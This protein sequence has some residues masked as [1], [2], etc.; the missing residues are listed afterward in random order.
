MSFNTKEFNITAASFFERYA[1]EREEL[2]KCL[3]SKINEDINL[4]CKDTKQKYLTGI[5]HTFC[6]IEYEDARRCQED[7][8]GSH[9]TNCFDRMVKFGQCTDMT[10]RKL[11][12]FGLEHHRKNVSV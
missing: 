10:L 5:A 9:G 7:K 2:E 6:D 1:R 3:Q 12:V 8:A 4:I 11:Y